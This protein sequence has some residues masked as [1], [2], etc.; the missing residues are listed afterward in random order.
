MFTRKIAPVRF[1]LIFLAKVSTFIMHSTAIF[2]GCLTGMQNTKSKV[3]RMFRNPGTISASLNACTAELPLVNY[4]LLAV[5]QPVIKMNF[6]K[7]L[8]VLLPVL[9]LL[10]DKFFK[11]SLD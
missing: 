2:D 1:N 10:L 3:N 11:V 8:F 9:S 6:I 4:T 5:C 7:S